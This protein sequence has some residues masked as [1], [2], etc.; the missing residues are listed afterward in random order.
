MRRKN[1]LRLVAAS[2]LL[3]AC[4]ARASAQATEVGGK[5]LMRQPDG[6]VA[7]GKFVVGIM[8]GKDFSAARYTK[9]DDDG[10]Y[11]FGDVAP[12]GTYTVFVLDPNEGG[13]PLLITGIENVRPGSREQFNIT[14]EIEDVAAAKKAA[15]A[16]A[17]RAPTPARGG[18]SPPAPRARAAASPEVEEA[19][20]LDAEIGKMR[21]AGQAEKALP[22]ALKMR[23]I[24]AAALGPAHAKVGGAYNALGLLYDELGDFDKAEQ[25]FQTSLA[26]LEKALGPDNPETAN[27]MNNLATFY[28]QERHDLARAEPLMQRA[29]SIRLTA[30]GPAHADVGNSY[31]ALG[32]LYQEEGDL[33]KAEQFLKRALEVREKALGPVHDAVAESASNLASLYI[34]LGDF[35]QARRLVMRAVNVDKRVHGQDHPLYASSLDRLGLLLQ[36]M[37]DYTMAE[38]FLG[39]ALAIRERALGPNHPEV[40]RS[41][42]HLADLY[43]MTAQF[44]QVEPL[45]KRALA[46]QEKAYG[47]DSTGV[48]DSLEELARYYQSFG[49]DP[50][51]AESLYLRAVAIKEKALGSESPYLS[52]PLH[53]LGRLYSDRGDYAKAEATLRRALQ[54]SEKAYGMEHEDYAT[55]LVTL[56][57]MYERKGEYSAAEQNIL[58]A[59]SIREKALG[60]DHRATASTLN[61]IAELYRQKGDIPQAIAYQTRGNE[62]RERDFTRNLRGGSEQQKAL[63]LTNFSGETWATYTLHLQH[64]PDDARAARLALTTALQRKGRV[65]DSTSE[66]Y[67]ALRRSADK[68]DREL[69]D[70]L[71]KARAEQA[72][73]VVRGP[74]RGSLD[75]YHRR[76]DD[77]ASK[78]EGMEVAVGKLMILGGEPPPPVTIERVQAAIPPDAALV[79]M[80]AYQPYVKNGRNDDDTFAPERYAAYV[81]RRDG[82]LSWADLGESAP[83]NKQIKLLR[84]AL[85]DPQRGDVKQ[86]ARALDERVM[87]PLRRLL[88]ETRKVLLSP[89]GELNVVPFAALVD[90]SGKY[91]VETY[92]ITYLT[93]GRDLLRLQQRSESRQGP[94]IVANP[95][96]GEEGASAGGVVLND[97]AR[98]EFGPLPGTDGEARAL[99]EIVPGARLLTG[100]QATEAAIK[101]VRGPSVLHVATHGFFL[102]G[103]Q[104]QQTAA[105]ARGMKLSGAAGAAKAEPI[106]D[107][108]LRSGLALAG[109]NRRQSEGGEDGILTALEAAGLDLAGTKLVVLSACE[110][111]LG[112]VLAGDGVF[113]LR[114]SLV[115]AGSESQVMTLW[116]VSDEVTRDLMVEYYKRLQAGEGRTEA[117]RAVQLELIRGG[118]VEGGQNREINGKALAG[119]ADLSHPFFWAGFIESGD[120]RGMDGK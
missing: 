98:I 44:D 4:A 72:S 104:Q 33:A 64:A 5:V 69:L 105:S 107:P 97:Y 21:E 45:L 22:L 93:S 78:I 87:R 96:F 91:L 116:Q 80:I 52:P 20:R 38:H 14:V 115:L 17:R 75:D 66:Q 102:Q 71:L 55:I 56:A 50:A 27:V 57:G 77:S 120:W 9:T 73:L 6:T 63:Y 95:L 36:T 11:A 109:A 117:L 99:K 112:D 23:D 19:D 2:L 29:L 89:D 92:T 39:S 47:A 34:R 12:G 3:V 13:D 42:D 106:H 31:D 25:S 86:L 82:S 28:V 49:D 81:L 94:L 65:L 7:P 10:Q 35:D 58:R 113:G 85:R 15:A 48:L 40:A 70:Q 76:L 37:S 110:T 90:E 100:A 62:A 1:L 79:E 118:R 8:P 53:N 74:G 83:V 88:G 18:G 16:R 54:I 43:F 101:S 119:Q 59:L 24:Y 30:L 103:E 60:P 67:A 41:L 46:I 32:T 51:K 108:R 84:E 114:R 111:G 68:D 61:L 26:I